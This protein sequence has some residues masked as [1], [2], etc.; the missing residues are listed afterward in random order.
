MNYAPT[1]LLQPDVG[2]NV[3]HLLLV[4]QPE[5]PLPSQDRDAFN[6]VARG[7]GTL[8]LAG[9]SPATVGYARSLGVRMEP[10]QA[11]FAGYTTD[12][13]RLPLTSHFRLTADGSE[14]LLRAENGD[15]LALVKKQGGGSAIVL[16]TP[17]PL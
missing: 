4:I 15:V 16:A 5:A 17:D 3:P 10:A 7:G 6:Q 1:R 12:G 14:P 8:V 2:R 11:A 9:D 13:E